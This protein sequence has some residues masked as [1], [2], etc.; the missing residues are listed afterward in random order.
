MDYTVCSK[1]LEIACTQPKYAYDLLWKFIMENPHKVVINQEILEEYSKYTHN[2][3]I[4]EW[5]RGMDYKKFWKTVEIDQT[6]NIFI[7]TC[8]KTHDKNFIVSEKEDYKK[9]DFIG[10][11]VLNKDEA[12]TELKPKS[13][14]INQIGNN[15]QASTGNNS[16]NLK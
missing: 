8:Q 6:N 2:G 7:N 9:E 3:T 10:I 15:N 1:V 16:P 11:K 12:I 5:I 13:I 14:I 4:H